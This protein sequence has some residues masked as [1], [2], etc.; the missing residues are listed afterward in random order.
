MHGYLTM[1]KAQTFQTTIVDIYIHIPL[2]IS[3]LEETLHLL[4]QNVVVLQAQA[5][6]EFRLHYPVEANQGKWK[7]YLDCKHRC[8][9]KRKVGGSE[10]YSSSK[11]LK[12]PRKISGHINMPLTKDKCMCCHE[13]NLSQI[14]LT[15]KVM[16]KLTI[17]REVSLQEKRLNM[18]VLKI[19][20]LAV[21]FS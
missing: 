5:V 3:V 18:T 8:G 9:R 2:K 16:T 10:H 11:C 15:R 12:R 19:R 4:R 13:F 1:V 17:Y 7:D 21:A 6:A 20:L 14:Q